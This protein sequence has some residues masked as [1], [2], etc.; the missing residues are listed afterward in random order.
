MNVANRRY[1]AW[2][3]DANSFPLRLLQFANLS[4]GQTGIPPFTE[5]A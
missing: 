3:M 4:Q 2:Q 1:V 5:L